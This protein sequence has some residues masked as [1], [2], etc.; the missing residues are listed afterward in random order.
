M[1]GGL[2]RQGTAVRKIDASRLRVGHWIHRAT[3]SNTSYMQAQHH[4]V[5]RTHR[6]NRT[7]AV[8]A[9]RA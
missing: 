7:T 1:I 8:R 2:D 5:G 4:I 9:R 3:A 6:S